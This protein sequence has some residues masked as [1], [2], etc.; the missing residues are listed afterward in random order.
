MDKNKLASAFRAET[1]GKLNEWFASSLDLALDK[2]LIDRALSGSGAT[3]L[4][5]PKIN[6]VKPTHVIMDEWGQ[7]GLPVDWSKGLVL[8]RVGK[9][10]FVARYEGMRKIEKVFIGAYP[11]ALRE[12]ISYK[13]TLK[14]VGKR[15]SIQDSVILRKGKHNGKH[16]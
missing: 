4:W 12:F 1:K 14:L 6:G 13:V 10:R 2:V 15:E 8:T 16:Y 5:G 3:M 7:D 9:K 11:K